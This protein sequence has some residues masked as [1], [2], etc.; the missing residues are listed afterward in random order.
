MANGKLNLK[1][2]NPFAPSIT[3]P[4][5]DSRRLIPRAW[6]LGLGGCHCAIV[7]LLCL[8]PLPALPGNEWPW[9]DKAHHVLA[10][11]GL[12]AWFAVATPRGKW[13]Q[14]ALA[15]LGFGITIECAQSFVPYR[16][17]SAA[18]VL[19]DLAGIVLGA[20]VASVLPAGFPPL[21]P[22]K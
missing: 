18:D 13:W 15:L 19:A 21:R 11:A 3:K 12:M 10:F 2:E 1:A 20:W 7:L 17:A 5:T 9:S 4:M 22:A 16:S 8:L 14:V 6:W